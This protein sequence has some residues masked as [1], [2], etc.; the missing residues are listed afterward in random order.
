VNN[1]KNPD[2]NYLFYLSEPAFAVEL[3]L[4]QEEDSVSKIRSAEDVYQVLTDKEL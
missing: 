3:S 2:V 4:A 1:T